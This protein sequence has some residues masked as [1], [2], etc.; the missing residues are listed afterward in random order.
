MGLL[1]FFHCQLLSEVSE[2]HCKC[3]DPSF[4]GS[5]PNPPFQE[6][7]KEAVLVLQ[8]IFRGSDGVKVTPSPVRKAIQ[9]SK[10]GKAR[11]DCTYCT[12]TSGLNVLTMARSAAFLSLSTNLSM[13]YEAM[14]GASRYSLKNLR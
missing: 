13:R 1:Y 9:E 14:R 5:I 7:A 12:G 2:V 8:S 6:A 10:Q 4:Y 11:V 3:K